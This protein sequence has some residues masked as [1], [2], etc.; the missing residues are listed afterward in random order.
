[1]REESRSAPGDIRLCRG[2][3]GRNGRSCPSPALVPLEALRVSA[4][5]RGEQDRHHRCRRVS[6]ARCR[7]EADIVAA[8]GAP[9]S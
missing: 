4:P 3:R 6:L 9:E 7:A 8:S 2:A 1:M 5:G